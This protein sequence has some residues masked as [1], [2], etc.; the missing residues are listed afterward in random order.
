M[1]GQKL[2]PPSAASSGKGRHDM[3][4]RRQPGTD[5]LHALVAGLG[6]VVTFA[7]LA[8]CIVGG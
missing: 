6:M 5:R 4:T 2:T 7:W 1:H 3:A 8:L